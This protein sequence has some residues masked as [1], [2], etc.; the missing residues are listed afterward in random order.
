MAATPRCRALARHTPEQGLSVQSA[1]IKRRTSDGENSAV[2]Q[3]G[4]TGGFANR[5]GPFAAALYGR[6]HV[7]GAGHGIKSCGI[8]VHAW[9]LLGTDLPAGDV[10]LRS[11][12]NRYRHR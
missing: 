6:S 3:T 10:G 11:F 4:W 5:R 1:H 7:K 9:V 12:W 8:H 2:S